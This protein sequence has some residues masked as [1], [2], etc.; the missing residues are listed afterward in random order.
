MFN[1]NKLH[2]FWWDKDKFGYKIR[3]RCTWEARIRASFWRK[4]V[5]WLVRLKGPVSHFPGGTMSCAPPSDAYWLRLLIAFR[6]TLV[7][8][9][10]PSPT[11]P[12]SVKSALCFLQLTAGYSIPPFRTLHSATFTFCDPNIRTKEIT[13]ITCTQ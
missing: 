10:T 7:L 12:K 13:P 6:K 5:K 8:D 9:L 1:N 3:I 11:P 4:R 2:Y